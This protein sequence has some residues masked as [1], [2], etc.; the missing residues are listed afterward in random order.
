[1]LRFVILGLL[2]TGAPRHGYALMKEYRDGCDARV[3]IGNI[4]RELGHLLAA[5]WIRCEPNPDGA[6]PRRAPYVITASGAAAFDAWLTDFTVPVGNEHHDEL[7]TRVFL[8]G[9]AR[10]ALPASVLERWERVLATNAS[11]LESTQHT[12]R[13]RLTSRAMP[14]RLIVRRRLK[15]LSMDL[16]FLSEVRSAF[17]GEIPSPDTRPQRERAKARSRC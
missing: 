13:S 9:V 7:A 14:A 11:L 16:D 3:S 8:A 6:D 2:R 12:L 1:M 17:S 10:P 4:Y 15:R 5:G